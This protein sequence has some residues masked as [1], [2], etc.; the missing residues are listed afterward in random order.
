MKS[1]KIDFVYKVIALT[2]FCVFV[3][4]QFARAFEKWDT[5]TSMVYTYAQVMGTTCEGLYV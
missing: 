5:Y 1:A 2:L 3:L 4:V